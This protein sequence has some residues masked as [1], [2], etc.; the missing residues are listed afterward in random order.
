M[1]SLFLGGKHLAPYP[2][3]LPDFKQ[4]TE[5]SS[6]KS[7][8]MN[9]TNAT[10]S[11]T[12]DEMEQGQFPTRISLNDYIALVTYSNL[13]SRLPIPPFK[14][15]RIDIDKFAT[16]DHVQ[17]EDIFAERIIHSIR[18]SPTQAG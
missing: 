12:V 6:E 18:S 13:H 5:Y 7:I 8:I 11:Q 14:P 1:A 2:E 9:Q 17:A 16:V 10:I 15:K 4:P 3:E